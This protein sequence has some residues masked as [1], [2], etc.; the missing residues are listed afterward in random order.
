MAE[1]HGLA[2]VQT[3]Q[4]RSFLPQ[5]RSDTFAWS[6]AAR[7]FRARSAIVQSDQNTGFEG[8]HLAL[9]NVRCYDRF[10]VGMHPGNAP[11]EFLFLGM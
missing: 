1:T 10:L 5:V 4:K 7:M 3:N 6:N 11:G 8:M 2:M 9:S